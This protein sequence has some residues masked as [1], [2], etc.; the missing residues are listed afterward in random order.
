MGFRGSC[1][2]SYRISGTPLL[3]AFIAEYKDGYNTLHA[4]RNLLDFPG[5]FK[6]PLQADRLRL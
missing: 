5:P 1:S 3:K 2:C 6:L 4:R